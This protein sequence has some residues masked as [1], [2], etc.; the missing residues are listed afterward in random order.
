MCAWPIH[1][2]YYPHHCPCHVVVLHCYPIVAVIES[3]SSVAL[4]GGLK[5]KMPLPLLLQRG[6]FLEFSVVVKATSVVV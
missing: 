4:L 6:L 3:S 1:C 5:F 2:P